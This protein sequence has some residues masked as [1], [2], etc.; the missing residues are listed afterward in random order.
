M[1]LFCVPFIKVVE[2]RRELLKR[3]TKALS[4]QCSAM[5]SVKNPSILK[6]VTTEG[7][8]SLTL[9]AINQE[10]SERTPIFYSTLVASA[11]SSRS[12]KS[13]CGFI[14]SIGVAASVLLKQQCHTINGLQLI[15]TAIMTFS[16]FHVSINLVLI[17]LLSWFLK[18]SVLFCTLITHNTVLTT[19]GFYL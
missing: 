8:R 19:G 14:L 1:C 5:T 17:L 13:D 6:E 4:H 3:F 7:I 18:H 10:L 15:V 12:K 2:I 11:V 9:T 16:G